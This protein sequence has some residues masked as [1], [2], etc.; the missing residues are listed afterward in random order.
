[1]VLKLSVDF[2]YCTDDSTNLA[3]LRIQYEGSSKSSSTTEVVNNRGLLGALM[4]NEVIR[5]LFMTRYLQCN[6]M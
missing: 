1:M 6:I 2:V 4:D 5:C 3:K